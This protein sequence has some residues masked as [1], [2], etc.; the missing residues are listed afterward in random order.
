MNKIINLVI[1]SIL[2]SVPFQDFHINKISTDLKRSNGNFPDS[3]GIIDIES[4]SGIEYIW[5]NLF[6]ARGI[7]RAFNTWGALRAPRT[8][9]P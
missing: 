6:F 7:E 8:A 1:I 9:K 4:S 5:Q 3:N 2:F